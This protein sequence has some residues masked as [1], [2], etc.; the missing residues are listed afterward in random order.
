MLPSRAIQVFLVLWPHL[1]HGGLQVLGLTSELISSCVFCFAVAAS[2]SSRLCARLDSPRDKATGTG[3]TDLST[4][5]KGGTPGLSTLQ[6]P[7]GSE[8]G[9][10][11]PCAPVSQ[12]LALERA[13]VSA[14]SRGSS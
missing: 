13:A 9:K 12:S 8:T 4:P 14:Y 6:L 10:A 11:D 1:C 2:S 5:V 7:V 3:V